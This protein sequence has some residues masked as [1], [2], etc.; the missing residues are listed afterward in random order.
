MTETELTELGALHA[1]AMNQELRSV[2]RMV[3]S[4][5]FELHM[6]LVAPRMFSALREAWAKAETLRWDAIE[7]RGE[8]QD[9]L[10]DFG[11]LRAER[12]T[13]RAERDALRVENADLEQKWSDSEAAVFRRSAEIDA[14]RAQLEAARGLL[15][16]ARD[17]YRKLGQKTPRTPIQ[18]G[19]IRSLQERIDA[20]LR[21][22][23]CK[24]C[25]QPLGQH[26]P[27][28]VVF[29]EIEQ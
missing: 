27:S 24:H 10:A 16:E 21:G 5:R 14:L 17:A 3:A 19:H 18:R 1:R 22:G 20:E 2:E 23:L 12:D 28:C 11:L 13:A 8:K 25:A 9:L 26:L 7:A 6:R 4:K 15:G 29:E